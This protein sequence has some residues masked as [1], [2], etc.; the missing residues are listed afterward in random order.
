M[1]TNVLTY[2]GDESYNVNESVDINFPS[3]LA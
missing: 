3:A 2:D 1:T